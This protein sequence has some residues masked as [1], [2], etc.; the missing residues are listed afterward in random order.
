[1]S[2][3]PREFRRRIVA[4]A[5]LVLGGG[6]M[7]SSC[8]TRVKEAVVDG[9]TGFIL[10]PAIPGQIAACLDMDVATSSLFCPSSAGS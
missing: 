8:Q 1:M 9:A 6:T 10:S 5:L 3:R 2:R 7:F 4:S